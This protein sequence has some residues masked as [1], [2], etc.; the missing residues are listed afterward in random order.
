MKKKSE[1]EAKC[2]HCHSVC[3]LE[4][5]WADAPPPCTKCEGELILHPTVTFQNEGRLDQCPVCGGAHLYRQK[6]F[7][8]RLGV[9]IVLVGVL[10]S[11]FTYGLSLLAVALIDWFI[12]RRVGEVASCYACGSVYRGFSSVRAVPPFN[13]SLHDYYRSIRPHASA[14]TETST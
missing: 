9:A 5:P 8:R 10:F 14:S 13:L 6:D 7:N 11:Y 2:P 4:Y 1:I 3:F 12:Y